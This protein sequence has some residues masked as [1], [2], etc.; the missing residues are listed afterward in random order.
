MNAAIV[1]LIGIAYILKLLDQYEEFDSLHW[2]Q[3]VRDKYNMDKSS[4]GKHKSVVS[5]EDEKLQQTMTL[6]ARRL[7]IYQQVCQ[8]LLSLSTLMC[9]ECKGD[10]NLV[11]IQPCFLEGR[12]YISQLSCKTS[13]LSG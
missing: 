6:T 4:L 10:K 13:L 11:L 9:E 8:R 2:F 1:Y 3:S 5:K 12:D 7:D